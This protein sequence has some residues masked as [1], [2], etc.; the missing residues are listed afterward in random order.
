MKVEFYLQRLKAH[1][2]KITPRRKATIEFLLKEK[3]YLSPQKVRERLSGSFPGISVSTVY[4]ILEEMMDIGILVKIERE[5]RMHYFLCRIPDK[6][7]HHFICRKC[8]RV[9]EVER[10]EF[11]KWKDFISKNLNCQLETHSLQ[12]EGLCTHCKR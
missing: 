3:A 9:E 4:R 12:L 1:G 7:H 6:P 2:F 10:C 5:G 11:E 8:G